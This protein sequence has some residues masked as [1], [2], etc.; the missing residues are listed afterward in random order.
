MSANALRNLL[1]KVPESSDALSAEDLRELEESANSAIYT[2]LAGLGGIGALVAHAC[3]GGAWGV[4]SD[5]GLS[6][7]TLQEHL[8]RLIDDLRD[9]E[10]ESAYQR[11][12]LA[13]QE[14]P[15]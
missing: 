7:G 1:I 10:S 6:I 14:L 5:V 9:I 11:R 2:L 15:A 13:T 8:V 4:D 12:K 3:S